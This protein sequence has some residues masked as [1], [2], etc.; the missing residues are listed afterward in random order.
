MQ[1]VWQYCVIIHGIKSDLSL[2]LLG[3]DPKALI[4][5]S[6]KDV[7][8]QNVGPD[9]EEI[10][11][12][13]CITFCLLGQCVSQLNFA[14]SLTESYRF[15][16]NRHCSTYYPTDVQRFNRYNQFVNKLAQV[17]LDLISFKQKLTLDPKIV[18]NFLISV[19]NE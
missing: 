9:Y 13:M 8:L 18:L 6:L 17:K 4:S 16:L 19:S 10:R 1:Q 14:T 5:N 2:N 11:L 12:L 15:W 3:N 7:F